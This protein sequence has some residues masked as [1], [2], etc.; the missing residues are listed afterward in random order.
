MDNLE[1]LMTE[2]VRKLMAEAEALRPDSPLVLEIMTDD[3]MLRRSAGAAIVTD[4]SGRETIYVDTPR[5]DE[6]KLA[7]EIMHLVLHRSG[8]PQ[9]YC[10]VPSECKSYQE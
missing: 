10:I 3:E 1:R 4:D 9:M 5:I 6:Y 2:R 8:W 7:H